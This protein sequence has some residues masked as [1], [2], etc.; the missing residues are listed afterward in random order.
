MERVPKDVIINHIFIHLDGLTAANFA[1]VSKRYRELVFKNHRLN[2]LMNYHH[3]EI[4]HPDEFLE[5]IGCEPASVET[6]KDCILKQEGSRN[7][8]DKTCRLIEFNDFYWHSGALNIPKEGVS[9]FFV[10]TYEPLGGNYRFNLG[11][12]LGTIHRGT[13]IVLFF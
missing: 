3:I 6:G 13:S 2:V 1:K 8:W 7:F 12:G 10:I 5:T 9:K 4:K 11:K